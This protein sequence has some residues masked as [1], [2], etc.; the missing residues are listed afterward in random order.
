MYKHIRVVAKPDKARRFM[1]VLVVEQTHVGT[2]FSD[3]GTN[4]DSWKSHPE[5]VVKLASG[6]WPEYY[7]PSFSMSGGE[8][9][10]LLR[11]MDRVQWDKPLEIPIKI[12]PEVKAAIEAYNE[13]FK[14]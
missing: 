1:H 12:W 14:E 13:Y 10:V 4:T 11:G 5:S 7:P 6:G 3:Q 2:E 8:H 9:C